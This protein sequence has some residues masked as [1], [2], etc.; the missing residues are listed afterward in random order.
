MEKDVSKYVK[1][2]IVKPVVQGKKII[3]VA[4]AEP[5]AGSDVQGINSTAKKI[6]PTNGE[7]AYYILNGEKKFCTVGLRCDYVLVAATTTKIGRANGI[8]FLLVEP[9]IMSGV[10]TRLIKYLL[11]TSQLLTTT[12][13][14]QHLM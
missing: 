6:Q 12:N 11:S 8:S 7:E 14:I 4:V 9:K 3:A 10:T 13:V 1:D 2:K 5:G